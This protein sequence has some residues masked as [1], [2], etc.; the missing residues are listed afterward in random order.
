[1]ATNSPNEGD[2]RGIVGA[3]ILLSTY[4]GASFLDELLRSLCAQDF[5]DIDLLVRDDGSNDATL[6]I[7]GR[8]ASRLRIRAIEHAENIGACQSFFQL[9][10]K[11]PPDRFVLLAD[12][13]DIWYPD[14][15]S[16]AVAALRGARDAGPSLYCARLDVCDDNGNV[17]NQ[18]PL[19]PNPP[20]FGNALVENIATGCT[21]ALNPQLVRLVQGSAV[22][23]H[24][25]MHDWWLYLIATAF[26]TVV[27]DP[28]P[29][30]S[31]RLHEK[32]VVGLPS[33]RANWLASRIRRQRSGNFA[34]RVV[35]QAIEFEEKFGARLGERDAAAIALL[36]DTTS[37]RGRWR[38][39]RQNQVRRQ[40]A[41]DTL[42]LKAL[43]AASQSRG[44]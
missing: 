23:S 21:V 16:R 6:D 31:Y 33:G 2:E 22:P 42:A 44:R 17:L 41:I 10:S 43:V 19:W 15:V 9:L 35:P 12:Q 3:T 8:W 30:A 7:L 29:C 37:W 20:T 38:F 40:F 39:I 32:N 36:R 5:P 18:S 26:G 4:N 28:R 13:D 1:M 24:A 11:A 27:Y 14:K 34:S 25:I